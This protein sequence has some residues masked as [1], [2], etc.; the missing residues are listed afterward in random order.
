MVPWFMRPII[1]D[2]RARPNVIT[3][4]SG[5]RDL[6]MV[7]T[8]GGAGGAARRLAL[9][10][11]GP[12]KQGLFCPP[13]RQHGGQG[14]QGGPDAAGPAAR[15]CCTLSPPILRLFAP[16]RLA[17][18]RRQVNIGLRVL[19]RP[20]PEK[21]PE[22]YR[23]LGTD[24]AERVLPSIIQAR[25]GGA[26]RLAGIFPS[27]PSCFLESSGWEG[28]GSDIYLHTGNK[29]SAH[30]WA[31]EHEQAQ[32]PCEPHGQCTCRYGYPVPSWPTTG[33][34]CRRR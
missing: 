30:G 4:T 17:C 8:G 18:P 7:G 5:S 34:A 24:Y 26:G 3:S 15:P 32:R 29:A 27:P 1:Y 9:A 19:T 2:V 31:G 11:P 16:A 10:A 20:M 22:I 13:A 33:P 23:T 12:C 14:R 6:Q 25:Q 28:V 21:L